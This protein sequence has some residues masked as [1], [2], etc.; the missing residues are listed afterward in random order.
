ME[1]HRERWKTTKL[2]T[3]NYWWLGVMKKVERYVDRYNACQYY[4]NRSEAPAEKLM[5]NAILEKP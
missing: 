5:P 3:R 1:G 4:K 2:V